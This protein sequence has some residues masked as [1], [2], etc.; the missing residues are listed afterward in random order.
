[1]AVAFELPKDL[2]ESLREVVGDLSQAARDAFLASSYQVGALSLG[3]LADALDIGVI[4]AQLWLSHR[5][6]PLNYSLE[7]LAQDRKSLRELFPQVR[8]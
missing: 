8:P 7:E 1:M 6:V 4:Q 2:E 3:E 5:R